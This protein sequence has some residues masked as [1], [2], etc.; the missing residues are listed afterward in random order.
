MRPHL[1]FPTL[2]LT[3]VLAL[4]L[5][6][7]AQNTTQRPLTLEDYGAW[8]RITQVTLSPDGAWMTYAYD[9]NDGDDAFFVKELDGD[10]V[11]EAVNGQGAAFSADGR[12][13]AFLTS[14]PED[15][16]EALREE[17]KPVRRTLHLV[18]LA[19]GTRTEVAAVRSFAFS[20]D[21]RYLGVHKERSDS[22]AEHRGSDL[23]LQDLREGTVLPLGNVAEFAFDEAGSHLA[24][25]VDAAGMTGNGAYL[26]SPADGRIRPLD[27]GA[28]R[29]ED[30]AWNDAGDALAA[31]RG[32]TPEGKTQRANVLVVTTAAGSGTPRTVV[33]DPATDADFPSGFVLS[34]LANTRWTEDGSRVVT[35]IKEQEDEW[36]ADE[37]GPNVDVWHW[38]DERL[39]SR[40]MVQADAD[41]R[42]TY[43]SVYDIVAGRFLRLA[44]DDMRRVDITDDGRWGIGRRDGDYRGDFNVEG[45]RADLVRIDLS[46]GAEA[47][48]ASAVRRAVGASPDG[49]WYLYVQDEVVYAVGL[50]GLETTNLTE[51]TGVDFIDREFDRIAERP[52]YGLAGWTE[53]GSVLLNTRYDVWRVP[54]DGGEATDLTGGTG[55]RQEIRFRIQRLDAEADWTDP[56]GALLSAYGEW[57]KKSGYFRMRPGRDP[58]ELVWADEMIGQVR[59]ASD[60]DRVVFTRQTFEVFPDY[61]NSDLDF[62]DA[63]RVTDA[64]PQI[65][66]FAWGRRVLIDYTDQRGNELQATLALPAGYV[67]GERYP[68]VVYFYEK[69]SQRHHQFSMPVYDDRPHMST[70][71]SQ[72]Y[73]VLMPDIV[74][75]DGLPGSSALDDVTAA[76]RAAIVLGYADPERIGLQGHSWG[77]YQSSFIVTQTD[78][79]RAVVTGAPLTNLMSMYNINYKR[80]GGGNGP[81]LEWSQGRFGV[82][83]WDDFDLY[84]SQSP[85]HHAPDI[86]TPF[87]I[88]HG[89][90]DGAVDWNQGLEFFNAARRLGKEVIL[91]SYPGEPHHL[92][93][94]ANQKDFQTRMR[95]YFD[96]FLK[97]EPAPPWMTEGVPFLRKGREAEGPRVI[98]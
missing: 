55:G 32:H 82:T 86:T 6:A 24:Y 63:E 37:D 54:L 42:F 84:V 22:D 26:V 94:E 70:Y 27:T 34:E 62:D 45:N 95:Q 18:D 23:L 98:S 35:G 75:D 88:L 41:R 53:D 33:Y 43:T 77:G 10:A 81:I 40:Q 12:W 21:G 79:F 85:I 4:S 17:K 14:P 11:H 73:L 5:P 58:R 67:E 46:S 78:M 93:E 72:G 9:P 97:G 74:Y 68:M 66:E 13:V 56:D 49:A 57:T 83:P 30:L 1:R 96:H 52:A 90:D 89:T 20:E 69:M 64:N 16:A 19:S 31:L 65:A 91:L 39:Q 3:A 71:A 28:Y 7:G 15:E 29:Y 36:E 8:S 47:T 60:A 2:A 92:G 59:K 87:M 61:W 50:E 25:L 76:A 44:T 38:T 48:F 80:T 51:A